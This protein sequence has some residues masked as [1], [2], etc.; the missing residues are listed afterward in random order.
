MIQRTNILMAI[1]LNAICLKHILLDPLT[2]FDPS[3]VPPDAMRGRWRPFNLNRSHVSSFPCVGMRTSRYRILANVRS[4]VH[5]QLS[6]IIPFISHP[7]K[8]FTSR[9]LHYACASRDVISG[10]DQTIYSHFLY[11]CKPYLINALSTLA[12]NGFDTLPIFWR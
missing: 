1:F 6:G 4:T 9:I 11:T 7:L 2:T 3:K 5:F 12:P 8:A 10:R